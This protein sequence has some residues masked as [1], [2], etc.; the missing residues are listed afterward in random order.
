MPDPAARHSGEAA[1]VIEV[2]PVPLARAWDWL[3]DRAREGL[4]DPKTFALLA[5]VLHERR[6]GR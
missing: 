3:H 6:D 5:I 1:E 2:F 4:V